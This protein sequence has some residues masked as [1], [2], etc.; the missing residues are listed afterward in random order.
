LD[1]LYIYTDHAQTDTR[2][3]AARQQDA[4]RRILEAA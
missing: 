2:V 1:T 4:T 3:N